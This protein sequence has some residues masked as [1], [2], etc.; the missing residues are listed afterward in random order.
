MTPHNP[1]HKPLF[2]AILAI[3]AAAALPS[4]AED[5]AIRQRAERHYSAG[6]WVN[7][8]AMYGLLIDARPQNT[9]FYAR[10]ITSAAMRDSIQPRIEAEQMM[11]LRRALAARVPVDSLIAAVGRESITLGHA[12]IYERFLTAAAACEPWMSRIVDA[13]L[14]RYY[15][16]RR[17]PVATEKYARA[18]LTG[19]PDNTMWLSAL[20]D[21]QLGEGDLRGAAHTWMEIAADTTAAPTPPGR[22]SPQWQAMV[23]AALTLR[24]IGLTDSAATIMHRAYDLHPTPYLKRL[25]EGAE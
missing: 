13:A 10:A 2:A 25:T 5:N 12:Q 3:C 15:I 6:E 11:L 9:G 16:L 7:A 8:A 1:W 17:N 14:L 20:A 18:M 21:G 23:E 24:A 19:Q 4:N 22:T